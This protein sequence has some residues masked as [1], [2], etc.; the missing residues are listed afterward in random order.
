MLSAGIAANACGSAADSGPSAEF[1]LT[2]CDVAPIIQSKCQRCH[3]APPQHGAP[4]PLMTYD[5]TQ[6]L[7][8]RTDAPERKRAEDMLSVVETNY[9]PYMGLALDP[10]VSPLTCAERATLLDWLGKGAFPPPENHEDC[11]GLSPRLRACSD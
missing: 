10:P 8:P 5:D 7:S 2:Y 6:V 4:F 3:Q 11:H 9:M 1:E